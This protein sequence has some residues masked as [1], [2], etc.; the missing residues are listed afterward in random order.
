[1]KVHRVYKKMLN[2]EFLF[3]ESLATQS[4]MKVCN[5]FLKSKF[6]TCRD[7][8]PD[9]SQINKIKE[10]K[11]KKKNPL[12]SLSLFKLEEVSPR[13]SMSCGMSMCSLFGI[14]FF[15]GM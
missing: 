9:L 10:K 2:S 12:L 13:I 1:M 11:K 6:E 15:G 5:V 14:M 3:I 8:I 4:P 7:V